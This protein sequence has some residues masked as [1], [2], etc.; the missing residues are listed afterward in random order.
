M[1]ALEYLDGLIDGQTISDM[2]IHSSE[3]KFLKQLMQAE[4][5]GN[6]FFPV[7]TVDKLS[8]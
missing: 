5:Q 4:A 2:P 6:S 7:K 8:Q 1:T 3:L